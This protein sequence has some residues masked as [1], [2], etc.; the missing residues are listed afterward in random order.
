MMSIF[1]RVAT[2][3]LLWSP[4]GGLPHC[5]HPQGDALPEP[6]EREQR[7]NTESELGAND[8]KRGPIADD[9]QG[10]AVPGDPPRIKIAVA[11][12]VSLY[13]QRCGSP[14]DPVSREG[15]TSVEKCV[16]VQREIASVEPWRYG[17]HA[18]RPGLAAMARSKVANERGGTDNAGQMLAGTL[19][20]G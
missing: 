20:R 17:R 19:Q 1:M 14:E 8:E 13:S 4:A 15:D 9:I 18:Q 2:L 10:R 16:P 6:H 3:I 7:G 11:H 12:H 5:S